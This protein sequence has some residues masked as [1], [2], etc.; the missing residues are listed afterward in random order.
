MASPPDLTP[1]RSVAFLRAINV[2]GRRVTSDE[3]VAAVEPLGLGRVDTFLASGNLLFEP[4]DGV[5]GIEIGAALEAA[6]G[7]PVPTTVRTGAEI[8]ALV[9]TTPFTPEELA[10]TS[11]KTQAILLFPEHHPAPDTTTHQAVAELTPPDDRLVFEPGVIHWLPT[12]GISTSNL[13]LTAIGRLVGTI[14]VR[15]T[16]TITRLAA[17]L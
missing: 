12:D 4:A 5:T 1:P 17:R 6:L 8:Q 3:L 10:A 13:D 15:T 16:N 7:Y 11:G 2:G 9:A 14:T